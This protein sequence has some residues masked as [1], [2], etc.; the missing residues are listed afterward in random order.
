MSPDVKTTPTCGNQ[1]QRDALRGNGH[2]WHSVADACAQF[3]VYQR[4]VVRLAGGP[5]TW[6]GG[7]MLSGIGLANVIDGVTARWNLT[8]VKGSS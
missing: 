3:D 4:K 5:V 1:T 6:R 7:R 8:E 2:A